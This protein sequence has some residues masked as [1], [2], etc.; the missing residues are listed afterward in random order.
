[1]KFTEE[2]FEKKFK[3]VPTIIDANKKVLKAGFNYGYNVQE[4][5]PYKV[6][7]DEIEK[8]TYRNINGNT[9]TA[10]GLMAASE[11]ANLPL[12][13]GSYP[14]TPATDILHELAK[15]KDLNVKTFQAEDEI[16]GISSSIGAS[17]AGNFAVTTTSGPGLALKTEA[18][19]LAL[20]TELPLVIV[21]VQRGGPSTGLPTKTE[22][23]DLMQAVQGRNGE[24]PLPVIAASTPA[25]CYDY[26][27]QASK[28]A[29]EHMT[30]V[31]LLTDGF[32]ANGTQPMKIQNTDTL[33]AINAPIAKFDENKAYLPYERDEETLVR[34][35]ATPG[36]PGLEHRIGGLE[37]MD[38]TGTVSYVPEN[39]ELMTYYRQKK[40]DL[41]AN[42]I[43]EQE[44]IGDA[45]AD[46]LVVGWG[47][48]YGHLL[49]VV[50]DL[51]AQGK[52]IS[53][54][55]FNY[56]VPLPK[57]TEEILKGHKKIVVAE[58]NGGQFA[59]Y[60]RQNFNGI[61]FLQYNKVMG[62]PF[63]VEELTVHFNK[64]M[65]EK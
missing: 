7:A 1:L 58:I 61:E 40:V 55:H 21:N 29:L 43:P 16:A 6:S 46:L 32:L 12:F 5:T 3:K 59:N 51:Q 37:K 20:I 42:A 41:V 2:F 24:A 14:I 54:A 23:S 19:G 18:I 27:F 53:L 13:C 4:L 45:E 10:W 63:T 52:K 17:F 38:K 50:H 33:P 35:W 26:A 62:L 15:H 44:L 64:L 8:G 11:K 28:I 30:P 34:K 36:T 49:T 56:I 39:H 9:A 60:L 22:Q 25:N 31:I 65:E 47:G 48:T 57:N